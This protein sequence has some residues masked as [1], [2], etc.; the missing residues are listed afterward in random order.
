MALVCL[1]FLLAHLGALQPCIIFASHPSLRLG[2]AAY[3]MTRF[4][5]NASNLLVLTGEH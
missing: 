5:A 4:R 3:F 1:L 2:E